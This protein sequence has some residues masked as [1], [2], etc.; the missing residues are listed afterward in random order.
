[1]VKDSVWNGR[2][3]NQTDAFIGNF[4]SNMLLLGGAELLLG[5]NSITESG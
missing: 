3:E 1:M 2:A 4:P 5:H